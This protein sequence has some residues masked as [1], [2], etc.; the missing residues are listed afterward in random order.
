[1]IIMV[2]NGNKKWMFDFDWL[3]HM[4]YVYSAYHKFN[5]FFH[6]LIYFT[7]LNL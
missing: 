5:P 1:M 3:C 6:Q 7:S 2:L 4:Y